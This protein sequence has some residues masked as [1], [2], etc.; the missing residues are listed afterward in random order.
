VHD[1]AMHAS[2]DDA[3]GGA[4]ADLCGVAAQQRRAVTT[5]RL[6]AAQRT[7]AARRVARRDEVCGARLGLARPAAQPLPPRRARV[8]QRCARARTG[9]DAARALVTSLRVCARAGAVLSSWRGSPRQLHARPSSLPSPQRAQ[10]FASTR[11]RASGLEAS[12]VHAKSGDAACALLAPQPQPRCRRCCASRHHAAPLQ[13]HPP[14]AAV[15]GA[16][17]VRCSAAPQ[18]PPAPEAVSFGRRAASAAATLGALALGVRAGAAAVNAGCPSFPP[19]GG[20]YAV[21]GADVRLPRE[22]DGDASSDALSDS[23]AASSDDNTFRARVLYPCD[24]PRPGA[25]QLRYMGAGADGAAQAASLAGIVR[26]PAFLTAH[27][28]DASSGVIAAPPVRAQRFPTLVYSHGFG[29]NAQMGTNVLSEIASHGV[30]VIAVEHTDGSASRT[31]RADGSELRFGERLA[32]GRGAGLAR[33]VR[34]LRAAAR[35]AAGGAGVEALPPGVAAAVDPRALF[36]GGHSYGAPTALL[37]LRAVAP[38]PGAPPFAG[39]LMHDAALAVLPE[40]T[41]RE[42]SSAPLLFLLSDEYEASPFTLTPV[43]IA[44]HAAP[45]GSGVYALAGSAH[46][47]YVDAPFWSQRFVMRGLAKL[48]IPAAGSAP[49]VECLRAIGTSGGAFL[50]GADAGAKGFAGAQPRL[51]A[52]LLRAH[53]SA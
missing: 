38:R 32:G 28:A 51:S 35:A 19:L 50:A 27:L 4:P 10:L 53:S 41:L 37:A 43:M 14:P 47:N 40:S 12:M 11:A 36:L 26:F 30:I 3:S 34:E 48:G 5:R 33:R 15:R 29:G 25:P 1:I 16:Q 46:G 13:Q 18:P 2:D 39:A 24:F 20:P 45:P 17:R 49:A 7:A 42:P 21:G 31:V 23:G 52:L 8:Q 44:A 22:A 6:A 9:V